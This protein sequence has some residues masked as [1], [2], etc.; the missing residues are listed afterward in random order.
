MRQQTKIAG[1]IFSI[2]FLILGV[3]IGC[4]TSGGEETEEQTGE[5]IEEQIEEQV[6]DV[7]ITIGNLTDQTGVA[8][9]AMYYIGLALNDV[10]DYYNQHDL[11]PGVKL[12]VINYDEQYDASKD[13]P[14]Y[15]K[16][17]QEGAD[18]IWTPVP[19]AV[20]VLKPYADKDK[21]VIFTATA[22]MAESELNGGYIFSLGITPRQE[23]YTLLKW[24]A[25]NDEDFP[26]DR[27]ARFGAAA[28]NDG[29]SNLL[30][31]AAEE[32]AK[33]HPE[34]FEWDQTFLTNFNFNWAT[35][36]E[37]LI[38]RLPAYICGEPQF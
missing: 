4:G 29:Y 22:N 23:A 10:V 7:T 9:E 17:R 35:Q 2:I 32:Y 15:L 30:Y 37:E 21:F 34:Q 6:E 31:A 38:E 11:I 1:I 14:G 33:A 28:W 16:L 12:E 36:A 5:E 3:V 27:P 25:E 18:L 8:A 24:L 13:I 20:P 19:Q 26:T